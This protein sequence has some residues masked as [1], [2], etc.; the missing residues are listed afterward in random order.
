MSMVRAKPKESPK[1]TTI[2]KVLMVFRNA[3]LIPLVNIFMFAL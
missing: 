2:E 3:F 1:I